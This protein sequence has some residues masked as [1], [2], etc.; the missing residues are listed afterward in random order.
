MDPA[1]KDDSLNVKRFGYVI[2]A[3]LLVL[4]NVGLANEWAF[5]PL[6]F[7]FTMYFLTGSLWAPGLIR[8]FYSSFGK[9]MSR[10]KKNQQSKSGTD[11]FSKN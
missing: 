6:I 7:I 11:H 8:I 5:T 1:Q 2:S 9:Y 10:E 3:I 4:S